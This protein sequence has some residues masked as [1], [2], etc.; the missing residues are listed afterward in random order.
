MAAPENIF[1]I[2]GAS[3]VGDTIILKAVSNNVYKIEEEDD[4]NSELLMPHVPVETIFF[5]IA[6]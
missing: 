2:N 6:K 1:S 4:E 3:S 5:A